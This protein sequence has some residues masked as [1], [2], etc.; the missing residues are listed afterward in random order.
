MCLDFDLGAVLHAITNILL[1]FL[2][3]AL[4]ITQLWKLNLSHK[5]KIQVLSMFCVGF[6]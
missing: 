4:P 1:D 5:K 2:I 6:L 3:F